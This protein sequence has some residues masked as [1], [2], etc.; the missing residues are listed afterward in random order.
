M[1]VQ[2]VLNEMKTIYNQLLKYFDDDEDFLFLTKTF[3]ELEIGKNIHKLKLLLHLLV[4]IG[5]NRHRESN[6]F[7]KIERIINIFKAEIIEKFSNFEI[8]TIF[9]SN[10]RILLFIIEEQII[11]IDEYIAKRMTDRKHVNAN[12][13]QY[14][15]PEIK[16][17]V[18]ESFIRLFRKNKEKETKEDWIDSIFNELPD[19]F[20]QKR[21][22]AENDTYICSLIREDNVEE[23]IAHL[24]KTNISIKSVIMDSIFETNHFLIKKK[25]PTLIEYAAFY[26]SIQIF[27]YLKFE[28]ADLETDLWLY[29]IRG[30]NAELIHILEENHVKTI[31]S[32]YY[33][34][35]FESIKCHHNEFAN[36]IKDNLFTAENE[37]IDDYM[38]TYSLKSY[39]FLFIENNFET[40]LLFQY[41]Y[42][43][44]VDLL[45][46]ENKIDIN[47][48]LILHIIF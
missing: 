19:N 1:N 47:K 7:D 8:F 5:N 33:D 22:I 10:K 45:I 9:Q 36:Y 11:K 12:Y 4:K 27:N 48:K 28:G 38:P 32:L 26:G 21:K 20:Y 34:P 30:R 31:D 16:P 35:F 29:V 13:P 41:D 42:Y 46:Q 40:R 15:A 18:T 17:F 3:D 44:F 2:E 37:Y 39:N 14:F 23:F 6:F 43:M 25:K 24:N